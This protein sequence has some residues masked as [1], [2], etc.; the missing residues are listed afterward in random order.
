[1]D[2]YPGGNIHSLLLVATAALSVPVRVIVFPLMDW[3]VPKEEPLYAEP[4]IHPA[5][6]P[7]S[8]GEELK[9]IVFAPIA[10][11]VLTGSITGDPAA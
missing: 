9:V 1:V 5:T 4:T 7:K 2:G 10:E 3:M 11:P 6:T 8:A